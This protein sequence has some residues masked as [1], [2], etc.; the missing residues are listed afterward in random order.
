MDLAISGSRDFHNYDK[1]EKIMLNFL[2]DKK[3]NKIITGCANGT[4]KMARVFAKKYDIQ[5]IVHTA[6][7]SLGLKAGPIRNK[8]IIDDANYLIAFPSKTG[9]G[10]QSCQ[11]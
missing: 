11:K 9:K 6:D 2:S 7:W 10:T 4:D 3:T 5:L 1:F 8:K